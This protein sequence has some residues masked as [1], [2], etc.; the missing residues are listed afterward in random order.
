MKHQQ[1]PTDRAS[2][3]TFWERHILQFQRLGAISAAQFCRDEGLP[4]QSFK[5]WQK[6]ISLESS[7]ENR[8]H[9]HKNFIRVQTTPSSRPNTIQCT[10]PGGLALSWDSSTPLPVIVSLIQEMQQL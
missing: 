1:I 5:T 9:S 2:K 8:S 3:H 7:P 10:F 6:K 4:Y